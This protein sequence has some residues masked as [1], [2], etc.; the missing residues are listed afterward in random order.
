MIILTFRELVNAM[1]LILTDQTVNTK[2]VGRFS[3]RFTIEYVMERLYGELQLNQKRNTQ[4]IKSPN[5]RKRREQTRA[6]P[7]ASSSPDWTAHQ[8]ALNVIR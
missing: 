7:R 4:R 1:T 5:I 3:Y 2:Q 6:L 8:R